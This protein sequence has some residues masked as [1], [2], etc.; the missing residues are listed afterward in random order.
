MNNKG[1][2]LWIEDKGLGDC[3]RERDNEGMS[4]RRLL[5][6]Y[7]N[8]KWCNVSIAYNVNIGHI[9]ECHQRVFDRLSEIREQ[10]GLRREET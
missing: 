6:H 1:G 3:V 2:Y 10:V 7:S 4:D 8:L 9:R 5:Q